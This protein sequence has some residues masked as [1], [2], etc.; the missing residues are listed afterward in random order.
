M[1]VT[2]TSTLAGTITGW[3]CAAC[4]AE[5]SIAT[6]LPF[7]CPNDRGD[8]HHVLMAVGATAPVDAVDDPNPFVAF[9][10]GF[11]WAAFAAAHGMDAAARAAL[12]GGFAHARMVQASAWTPRAR[13]LRATKNPA[14]G[15][16]LHV[17]LGAQERTRTSTV[18]PAST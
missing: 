1:A 4:A 15:G 18:L 16:V 11:A 9:D 10:A 6:A 5:M 8:R 13:L 12:A 17:S 7:R 14:F 3:R 2:A